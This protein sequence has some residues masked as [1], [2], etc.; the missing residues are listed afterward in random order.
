MDLSRVILGPIV[1]EKS[2]RLKNERTYTLRVHSQ[3]TKVEVKAALRKFF[4]SDVTNVRVSRVRPKSRR[5]G[6]NRL[7]VKRDSYKKVMVTLASKALDLA[8]FKVS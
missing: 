3:A 7:M 5:M 4:D 8:A 1:T 6:Q 2:E